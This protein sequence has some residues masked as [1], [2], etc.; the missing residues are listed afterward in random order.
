MANFKL[1]GRW[2]DAIS[3]LENSLQKSEEA[4]QDQKIR[5]INQK[6]IDQGYPVSLTSPVSFAPNNETGRMEP[7]YRP[8]V[9]S[10]PV[11]NQGLP[12]ETIARL[13]SLL[14]SNTP[15]PV[16]NEW[17]ENKTAAQYIKDNEIENAGGLFPGLTKVLGKRLY[18]F[19]EQFVDNVPG[20]SSIGTN[21]LT[22]REEDQFNNLAGAAIQAGGKVLPMLGAG[23]VG[24]NAGASKA[25]TLDD[26]RRL[27]YVK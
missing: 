17:L 21:P 25:M 11:Q 27:G 8:K 12:S 15:V 4:L 14:G 9:S 3:T 1:A 22:G 7:Y 18:K 26:A 6:F 16:T 20:L 10:S 23:W 24:I 2:K 5:E 13:R 19:G